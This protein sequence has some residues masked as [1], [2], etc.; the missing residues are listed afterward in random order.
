MLL[1][2][3][4]QSIR[5]Q[6]EHTL[7]HFDTELKIFDLLKTIEDNVETVSKGLRA[8]SETLVLTEKLQAERDKH[9]HRLP[10]VR[11]ALKRLFWD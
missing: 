11:A 5:S 7:M 3:A 2:M 1:N 4:Q 8:T 10:S 9:R 6:W